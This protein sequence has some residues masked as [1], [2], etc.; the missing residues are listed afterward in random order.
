MIPP[1]SRQAGGHA[2]AAC[3][4]D[5]PSFLLLLISFD[6]WGHPSS[7][8]ARLLP[9]RHRFNHRHLWLPMGYSSSASP[10]VSSVMPE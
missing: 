2:E 8:R 9:L 3:Q 4:A 7:T 10:P 6:E 1:S 5:E